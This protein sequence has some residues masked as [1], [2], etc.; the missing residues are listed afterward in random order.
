MSHIKN[1]EAF[2]K[3]VG[4]CAGYGDKYNP[5]HQN[6]RIENMTALLASARSV[7]QEVGAAKTGY[8]IATNAR[9]IAYA[10]LDKLGIR[11]LSELRASGALSQTV[12][13]ANS[14]VRK[15]TGY[16]AIDRAA[17][18]QA[19]AET[20]KVRRKAV[21]KGL[22]FGS[23]AQNF[24]KLIQTVSVEQSYRPNII[25]LRVDALTDRLN[26]LHGG[27]SKVVQAISSLSEA[28]KKRDALLY[29]DDINLYN[30]A[31]TAKQHVKAAFGSTSEAY[32][33]VKKIQFTKPR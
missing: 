1:V 14:M 7:L 10:D 17:T 27:N 12:N 6:L 5:A 13:D 26:K 4:I 9:E 31:E 28:R 33:E 16:R 15:L 25:D 2:E 20:K 22:D 30:I 18:P 29:T 8:E 23:L 21:A 11:V 32:H 3:F 24:E 19:A